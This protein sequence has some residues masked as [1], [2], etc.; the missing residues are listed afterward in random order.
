MC[1]VYA[2]IPPIPLA[3]APALMDE[4]MDFLSANA[5]KIHGIAIYNIFP[6]QS[7][8]RYLPEELISLPI[9]LVPSPIT[10]HEILSAIVSDGVGAFTAGGM[11][12]SM[13]D[14]GIA[15]DFELD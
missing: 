11:I 10:P 1:K 12:S 14:L 6:D 5:S 3:R 9:M 13:S 2:S 15:L 7:I 8:L 4:Y